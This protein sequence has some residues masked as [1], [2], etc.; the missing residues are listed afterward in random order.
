MHNLP[1]EKCSGCSLCANVCPVSAITMKPNVEGFLYPS[2]DLEKCIACKKCEKFCP[3]LNAPTKNENCDA[4]AAYNKNEIIRK[5]SSSGGIFSL[6]AEK[7]IAQNGV[8]FGA[9]FDNDFSVSISYTETLDGLKEFRGS[10]YVQANPKYC[11][12][13]CAEFLK[14]GRSVLFTGTPCQVAALKSYL[15]KKR[16]DE[17]NL[18]AVDFIC[19]GTPAPAM[20]QKYLEYRKSPIGAPIVRTSFR[21][22]DYGWKMFSLTFTYG[23]ASEYINPLNKDKYLRLFLQDNALRNSCYTCSFRGLERAPDM[24]IADFWGIDTLENVPESFKEDKGTSLVFVHSEKGKTIFDSLSE[25]ELGKIQ[26]SKESAI[27]H[28]PAMLKS[29][30]KKALRDEFTKDISK[31]DIDTLYK[32]YGRPPFKIRLKQKMKNAIVKPIKLVLGE[33]GVKTLKKLLGR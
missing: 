27:L 31:F 6:L 7:I 3:E 15:Q 19:H 12:K 28:N 17:T 33:K 1:K 30:A 32:K 18:L 10:K 9:K 24:T 20:W 4:F 22:K 11:Y 2:V 5:E 8:V 26:V 25:K 14:A 13:E 29:K 23:D 21:R 16:I